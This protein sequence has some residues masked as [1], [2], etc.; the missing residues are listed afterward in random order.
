M[1]ETNSRNGAVRVVVVGGGFGGRYAAKRLAYRL[2]AGSKVTLVDRNDYMLYTPMLTEAAGRSVS[3][4]HI[5]APNKELPQRV[6]FVQGEVQSADLRKR[7]VTLA[8][9]RVLAGDHLLFALGSTTSYH[10][11]EG[12]QEH[13]LTMKTLEDARRVCTMAQRNVRQAALESDADKRKLLLNFIVAG[14]GYTGVET[15]AAINDLVRYTA[16]QQGLAADELSLTLVETSERLM[17]EMPESLATYSEEQLTQ[18]GIRVRT[19]VGVKMVSADSITLTNGEVV[20]AGMLIWDTGIRP[21]PLVDSLD[22]ER[23]KK[24]GIATDSTFRVLKRPGIWAI[25]DCAEIPKPHGGGFFEPTAQ[26]ATRE[27]THVADNIL[28]V[29]RGDK[30]EP[31]TY[32][33]IGELAVVSRHGGVANVFGLEI[34]GL[35]AWLMW[36][37]IYVA[38]MP[39]MRQ[40]VG[41]L[42]DYLRLAVGRRYVPVTWRLDPA[43][44]EHVRSGISRELQ[45]GASDSYPALPH[46]S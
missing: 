4:Q 27:G 24:G 12:A 36:R 11:I 31:F 29:V 10:G 1:A 17:S 15:M 33:Q 43:P 2:P 32:Q 28:A 8:D 41:L 5:Q 44:P 20:P 37:A 30:V 26:N 19:G 23:G 38:K 6:R 42:W 14:G 46:P 39:S 16:G 13:S 25:G 34:R 3:P 9:G 21:N 45:G 18:D 7:T 40:R 35:L 22:C